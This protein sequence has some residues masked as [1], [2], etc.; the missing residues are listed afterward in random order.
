MPK[1]IVVQ[2]IAC[3]SVLAVSYYIYSSISR[4]TRAVLENKPDQLFR[5]ND[6]VEAGNMGVEELAVMMDLAC[7]IS[8]FLTR[9]LEH[10]LR[11]ILSGLS[12]T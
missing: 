2:L 12:D 8:V 1:E 11:A 6:F 5:H 3:S 10:H 4:R 9:R 7:Q